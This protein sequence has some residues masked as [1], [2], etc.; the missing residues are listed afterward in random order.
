MI[1]VL[2]PLIGHRVDGARAIPSRDYTSQGTHRSR[3]RRRY[4]NQV[5]DP[6]QSGP[7]SSILWLPYAGF[8]EVEFV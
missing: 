3:W 7:Q 6:H 4:I 2:F 5:R 1:K 8:W